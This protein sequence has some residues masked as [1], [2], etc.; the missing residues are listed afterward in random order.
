M[1]DGRPAVGLGSDA[2]HATGKSAWQQH[3]KH[4]RLQTDD[5]HHALRTVQIVGKPHRRLRNGSQLRQT[6]TN[7]LHPQHHLAVD[8]RQHE[9]DGKR[10]TRL[11]R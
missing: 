4:T 3:G 8:T 6:P 11:T 2:S 10:T 1:F 5:E 7:A 9:R